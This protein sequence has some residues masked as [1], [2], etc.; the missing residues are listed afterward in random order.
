MS[1]QQIAVRRT[2]V[3]S[4]DQALYVSGKPNGLAAGQ[5]GVFDQDGDAIAAAAAVEEKIFIAVGLG[6]GLFRRSPGYIQAS[7]IKAV[8]FQCYTAPVEKIVDIT[9]ICTE[10]SGERYIKIR[11]QSS[12]AWT[13][14]G[15]NEYVKTFATREVC[16]TDTPTCQAIL[17]DLRDQINDD[18]EALFTAIAT[19]PADDSE[20]NDAAL[21]AWDYA[22]NGCPNLRITANAQAVAGFVGIPETYVWPTGVSFDVSV[23]GF[24]CCSPA[25]AVAVDTELT[26]AEGAGGDVMY[27]EWFDLGNTGVGPYR[28]T[29]SGVQTAHT[30]NAVAA[31]TYHILNILYHE[32]TTN[33][34]LT[35]G[36]PKEVL[37]AMPSGTTAVTL[38]QVL[39]D[40]LGTGLEAIEGAC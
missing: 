9:D 15:F 35:Y 5:V 4:G 10:C 8:N 7:A 33:G 16:C 30:L 39:D 29:A 22:A 32:P 40:Q 34:H 20:L 2:L 27:N 6:N 36:D 11:I 17:M 1:S 12:N 26:Y 37:V 13:G 21:D 23:K 3:G 24:T 14:Y 25:T 18:P 31:G 28:L 38:W 19:D